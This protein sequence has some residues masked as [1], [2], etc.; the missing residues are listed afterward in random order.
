MR[1]PEMGKQFITRNHGR[2][3]VVTV[4]GVEQSINSR[5]RGKWVCRNEATG[6]TLHRTSRQLRPVPV[7]E[8]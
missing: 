3:A 4:I 7:P 8:S 5:H 1:S 2:D 6:R